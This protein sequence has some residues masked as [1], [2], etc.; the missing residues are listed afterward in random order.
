[1]VSLRF[2]GQDL[3]AVAA[4]RIAG[5]GIARTFQ[6]LALFPTMTLLE[7]VMIGAHH[8]GKVGFV[9]AM[10]RIGAAREERAS[11]ADSFRDL[12]P[13][14]LHDSPSGRL[15]GCRSAR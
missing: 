1:M 14:D 15:P 9:R 3:S 6:N 8:L 11:A 5:L 2:D 4:H 12:R 10:I 13:L 7:N